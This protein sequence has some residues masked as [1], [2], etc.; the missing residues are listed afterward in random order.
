MGTGS[1]LDGARDFDVVV[2][3]SGNAG[4]S[5]AIAARET[6]ATVLVVEKASAEWAGGNSTFTAGAFRAAYESVDDLRNVVTL[7]DEEAVAVDVPSYPPSSYVAD[8]RRVTRDQCDPELAAILA[9]E[10]MDGA[11][12]LRRIGVRWELL[13]DRQSFLVDGRPRFWGNLVLGVVGGGKGLIRAE[14]D[15]ATKAGVVIRFDSP[16]VELCAEEG[17]VAGVVCETPSGPHVVRAGAVVI[18]SGGFEADPRQRATHLGPRWDL[19]KVRGTPHNTGEVIQLA[20]GLGAAAHGHWSGCHAIAWDA[21]A[22]EHGNLDVTNRYSRQGY[23]YGIVV[24]RQ[25]TRFLDEGADF[26]NYTYAKY[27]AEIMQQPDAIAFQLF[28]ADTLRLVSRVDYETATTSRFEAQSIEGLAEAMGII[29]D[30]LGKTVRAYNA[31]IRPGEFNPSI[32]DGK[33]TV[34][35][36]PP[37]SNWAQPLS[38]PPFTG[39]AVTCGITFT[40]GGVRMRSDG[41]VLRTTAKPVRGLYAC[42]ELVGGLFYHNYPGGAGLAAG[43]VFGRR[44]GR[45]A[46]TFAGHANRA[47]TQGDGSRVELG[48]PAHLGSLRGLD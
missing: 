41:A 8:M 12:W 29:P 39:F 20:L 2:V 35:I 14:L 28:D 40:F 15:A 38:K 11:Q 19:A 24:N 25:G 10:S 22:P 47:V 6:G 23:P 34:G 43:T 5:A 48:E 32:K 33:R 4:L 17:S 13:Y 44:A 3:G 30:A 27:G 37:K 26:R 21:F 18:A 46:A 31:A 9:E 45:T 42:G 1:D 7:S 16:V 36:E